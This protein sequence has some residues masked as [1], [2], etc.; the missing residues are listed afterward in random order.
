MSAEKVKSI[1]GP[2]KDSVF[3]RYV[4]FSSRTRKEEM[5]KLES[6]HLRKVI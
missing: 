2:K 6:T 4:D 3:Q 1:S 5:Q